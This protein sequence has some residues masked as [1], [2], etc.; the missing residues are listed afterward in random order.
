VLCFEHN[1]EKKKQAGSRVGPGIRRRSSL[2]SSESFFRREDPESNQAPKKDSPKTPNR[3]NTRGLGRERPIPRRAAAWK[4]GGR[5]RKDRL[6]K[7]FN[8]EQRGGWENEK[9]GEKNHQSH[10][11]KPRFMTNPT[12]NGGKVAGEIRED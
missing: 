12:E 10:P 7:A 5:L 11:V 6:R 4:T 8:E 9:G 1:E 2:S 3:K